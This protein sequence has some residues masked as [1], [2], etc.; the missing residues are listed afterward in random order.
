MAKISS[1][2]EQDVDY[3]ILLIN[4]MFALKSAVWMS[5]YRNIPIVFS[6]FSLL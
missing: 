2:L 1:K 4:Y 3:G 5:K 6:F